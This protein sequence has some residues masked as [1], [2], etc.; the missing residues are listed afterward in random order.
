MKTDNSTNQFNQVAHDLT[1]IRKAL[2]Q[3]TPQ[4]KAIEEKKGQ[5]VKMLFE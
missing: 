5:S 2:K 3:F 4:L 1:E